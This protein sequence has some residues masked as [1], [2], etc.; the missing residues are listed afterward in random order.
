MPSARLAIVRLTTATERHA[1]DEATGERQRYTDGVA[2][3]RHHARA[4]SGEHAPIEF[5]ARYDALHD[6]PLAVKVRR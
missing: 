1:G 3:I 2:D 4:R 6:E 5:A